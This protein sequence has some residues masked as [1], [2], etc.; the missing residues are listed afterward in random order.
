MKFIRWQDRWFR[1]TLVCLRDPDERVRCLRHYGNLSSVPSSSVQVGL[2]L[3]V[4]ILI[5]CIWKEQASSQCSIFLGGCPKEKNV[6]LVHLSLVIHTA[7][8]WHYQNN[9]P[10][11]FCPGGGPVHLHHLPSHLQILLPWM[12]SFGERPF[13]E[14]QFPSTKFP[15][16]WTNPLGSGFTGHISVSGS[17]WVIYQQ[18]SISWMNFATFFKWEEM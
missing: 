16:V 14:Y 8:W 12:E 4:V 6:F 5:K 15:F 9:Y 11:L 7:A 10:D 2:I 18:V 17:D 13:P 1:G 3:V